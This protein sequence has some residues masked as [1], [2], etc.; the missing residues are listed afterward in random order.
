[1]SLRLLV[2][3]EE[4]VIDYLLGVSGITA[5]IG[6]E[7]GTDIP[8]NPIYPRAVIQRLG[9]TPDNN[10]QHIDNPRLVCRAYADRG[11]RKQAQHIAATMHAALMDL[12]F[13]G[14]QADGV[15]SDCRNIVG[16][17]WTPDPNTG[18]AG[19]TFIVELTVHPPLGGVEGS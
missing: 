4:L 3:A 5:L 1:L 2:D 15:V 7:I 9:G 17:Q 13:N 8:P 14:D 18:R 10:E 6:Q 19:F 11:K 12:R 16:L